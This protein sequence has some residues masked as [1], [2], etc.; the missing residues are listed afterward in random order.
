DLDQLGQFPRP[1]CDELCRPDALERGDRG[2]CRYCR[3]PATQR[4]RQP[5]GRD[6][7]VVRVRKE[8]RR[9]GRPLSILAV[10]A[11]VAAGTVAAQQ[12][13]AQQPATPQPKS[14]AQPQP[15]QA[16]AQAQPAQ[17][18]R[19]AQIDRNGVL[20]LVRSTL[21]A[22]DHANKTG[23]YTVLRDLAAPG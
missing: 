7:G 10:L 21:L 2:Q 9:W 22:L 19:P 12:P 16:P 18:P 20:I 23:N 13:A 14:G 3:R 15:A 11:A 6:L 4:H 1:E 17:A 8:R 5:R